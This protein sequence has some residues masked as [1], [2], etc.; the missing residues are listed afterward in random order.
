MKLTANLIGKEIIDYLKRETRYIGYTYGVS[1]DD[2]HVL[3]KYYSTLTSEI[4]YYR[5]NTDDYKSLSD[6]LRL[7][8]KEHITSEIIER[9]GYETY[10][11]FNG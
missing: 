10:R 8:Y 4:Y 7:S 9:I 1:E 3:I 5:V 6:N 11:R 2:S